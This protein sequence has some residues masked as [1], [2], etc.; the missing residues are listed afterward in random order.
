[1]EATPQ[2]PGIHDDRPTSWVQSILLQEDDQSKLDQS[3]YPQAVTS[4]FEPITLGDAPHLPPINDLQRKHG[5]DSRTK[6]TEMVHQ[7]HGG[8]GEYSHWTNPSAIQT[9]SYG[10]DWTARDILTTFLT[11]SN[12]LKIPVQ[13]TCTAYTSTL[14]HRYIQV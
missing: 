3:P 10:W 12:T 7:Y 11:F 13:E 9:R 1:M 8:Q 6:A 5:I 2:K 4:Y 14:V